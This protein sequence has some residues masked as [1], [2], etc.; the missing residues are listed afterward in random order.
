MASDSN[1]LQKF[2]RQFLHNLVEAF[3]SKILVLDDKGQIAFVNQ[4]WIDYCI[5]NKLSGDLYKKGT[6]YLQLAR[7]SQCIS[8][9]NCPKIAEG[10]ESVM[11]GRQDT[12][13]LE[14]CTQSLNQQQW[15]QVLISRFCHDGRIW[16]LE[17][18]EN[19]TESK[20]AAIAIGQ[21]KDDLEKCLNKNEEILKGTNRE[22][23]REIAQRAATERK[24]HKEH[25]RYRTLVDTIPHG[26]VEIDAN[27]TITFANAAYYRLLGH[28][29]GSLMG[30][31]IWDILKPDPSEA[32][33]FFE[34]A[35]RDQP[36]PVGYFSRRITT[37]GK[38]V[39]LKIDWNYK[40]DAEGNVVGF[41]AVITDVTQLRQAEEESRQR[42]D[43]LAHVTR[44]FTMNQMIS[45]L[46]HELNQPLAAIA[47]FAQACRYRLDKSTDKARKTLLE[48]IEQISLQADRA[49]QIIRRL[50]DFV[51]RADSSHSWENINDLVS[52]VLGLLE[53]EARANNIQLEKDLASGLP[54]VTVD[55]IQIEQ[56]ITNLVKNALDAMRDLPPDR[57]RVI[58]RTG[59]NGEGML[60]VSVIDSGKGIE[61]GQLDR[62]FEPFFTTKQSG[63]GLGLSISRSIVEA[64]GG[65][66]EAMK[67]ARRG[68]TFLFVLPVAVDG[69]K[70]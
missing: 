5:K 66:L 36:V 39:D 8:H 14:Y 60:E 69:E 7:N 19:I 41:D 51:R 67:N 15:F 23:R 45:G 44:M 17:S 37:S 59:M 46:A 38:F 22:L 26:I 33:R 61:P 25:D 34:K 13:H 35:L 48:S 27:W 16:I 3:P 4:A 64:H 43:Q 32:R 49:G 21:I 58:V 18:H 30:K 53:I 29:T 68:M 1:G 56:V 63:M 47:N 11:A 55:R 42:L 20:K 6:D 10:I 70:A 12:F 2:S 54:K 65:R 9:E 52:D 50:R 31:C 62:I 24:I 40:R 28:P 57:C